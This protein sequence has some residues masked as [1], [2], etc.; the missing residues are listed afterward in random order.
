MRTKS[1]TQS[2]EPALDPRKSS[3]PL[4]W[5]CT[6]L[7]EVT[8]LRTIRAVSWNTW[9]KQDDLLTTQTIARFY[10][11]GDDTHFKQILASTK[12]SLQRAKPQDVTYVRAAPRWRPLQLCRCSWTKDWHSAR[13]ASI[14]LH[15]ILP[16]SK[17]PI[18]QKTKQ[19]HGRVFFPAN[20]DCAAKTT[21]SLS[22]LGTNSY[23]GQHRVREFL[24][25]SKGVSPELS[26]QIR[27]LNL[28]ESCQYLSPRQKLLSGHWRNFWM[29]CQHIL[30][31]LLH[32]RQRRSLLTLLEKA[33]DEA[34]QLAKRVIFNIARCLMVNKTVGNWNRIEVTDIEKATI[35]HIIP[36]RVQ[37]QPQ[38]KYGTYVEQY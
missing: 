3:H 38:V 24:Q 5:W 26:L 6:F 33:V 20:D 22:N 34:G 37:I 2:R 21:Q 8:G 19:M 27:S 9:E 25:D 32:K 35:T 36:P 18:Q 4:V 14:S 1:F 7:P 16:H 17:K 15:L 28:L 30:F 10:N 29:F 11:I 31:P 23:C 13:Q 12:T